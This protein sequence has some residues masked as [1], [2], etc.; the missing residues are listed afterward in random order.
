MSNKIDEI[1]ELKQALEELLEIDELSKQL[2]IFTKNQ[3]YNFENERVLT[4]KT[5]YNYYISLLIQNCIAEPLA[6]IILL[7][8]PFYN[9]ILGLYKINDINYFDKMYTNRYEIL[10]LDKFDINLCFQY[11][12]EFNELYDIAKKFTSYYDNDFN[13]NFHETTKNLFEY[14]GEENDKLYMNKMAYLRKNNKIKLIENYSSN[15]FSF[16]Q[17]SALNIFIGAIDGEHYDVAMEMMKKITYYSKKDICVQYVCLN[18]K[19]SVAI[20]II[21]NVLIK[22]KHD[23]HIFCGT[24]KWHKYIDCAKQVGNK[25]LLKYIEICKK[26]DEKQNYFGIKENIKNAWNTFINK[27]YNY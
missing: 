13:Y 17:E 19:T 11:K 20:D 22:N 12:D 14:D 7:Y 21:N 8:T 10:N 15:E 27:I 3:H 6:I 16:L 26:N 24:I 1:D 2:N 4:L 23:V 18:A 9:Y 25:D 5:T